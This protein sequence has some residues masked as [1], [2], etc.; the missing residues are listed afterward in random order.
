MSL[1]YDVNSGGC[2]K[3]IRVTTR[4][5]LY[6]VNSGECEKERWVTTRCL[7]YTMLIVAGVGRTEGAPLGVSVI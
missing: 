5:L 6:N 1:L 7:C 2:G 4:C 3:E